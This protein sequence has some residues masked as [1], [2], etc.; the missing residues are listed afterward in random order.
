MFTLY[1]Q[2]TLVEEYLSGREF[3]VAVIKSSNGIT[4]SFPIEITPPTSTSGLRILGAYAKATDTETLKKMNSD[5]I[6]SVNKLALAS[7][8]GL[9]VRGFGRIDVKMNNLGECYFM[10]ANLVPGMN[11]GTSYFPRA[12]E[13]QNDISY[14]YVVELMLEES[15]ARASVG[16]LLNKIQEHEMANIL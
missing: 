1:N 12:C 2:P 7:F 3:T 11:R 6:E 13:I 4:T 5:E 9:G 14:D 8:E 16:K 10:E 15:M